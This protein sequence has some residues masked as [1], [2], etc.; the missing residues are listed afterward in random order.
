M[1]PNVSLASRPTP[2]PEP[3]RSAGERFRDVAAEALF[4]VRRFATATWRDFRRRDRFFQWK[5]AILAA[6]TL[7][8]VFAIRVA[9]GGPPDPARNGLQAYTAITHTTM[10]WGLLVHNRSDEA[11]T[12]VR[13]LLDGGWVHERASVAADE[14]VVLSPDQFT[15]DGRPAPADLEFQ[16]V[17]LETDGGSASPPLVRSR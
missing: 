2:L 6:W 9:V 14:K 15:R 4:Q 17:R 11:W 10:S 1:P 12:E 8:S 16:T 3:P 7:C 5:A 13:V